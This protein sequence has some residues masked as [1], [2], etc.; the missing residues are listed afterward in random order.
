MIDLCYRFSFQEKHRQPTNQPAGQVRQAEGLD[1]VVNGAQNLVERSQQ[2]VEIFR[3]K[4][5]VNKVPFQRFN[6]KRCL[7][8]HG[9]MLDWWDLET[10]RD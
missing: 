4:T 10:W 5:G 3:C 9:W 1:K 6:V 2:A 8:F 7:G